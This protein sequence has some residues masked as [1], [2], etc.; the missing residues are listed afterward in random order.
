MSFLIQWLKQHLLC[1]EIV[2]EMKWMH[3]PYKDTQKVWVCCF[4]KAW[5]R[6]VAYLPGVSAEPC[7][8]F[9]GRKLARSCRSLSLAPLCCPSMA[10]AGPAPPSGSQLGGGSPLARHMWCTCG[11]CRFPGSKGGIHR[12]EAVWY[13]SS[14]STASPSRL[15][16]AWPSLFYSGQSGNRSGA[17]S[18]STT[19]PP[20]STPGP[21]PP[22]PATLSGW[23][24]WGWRWRPSQTCSPAPSGACHSP[25]PPSRHLHWASGPPSCKSGSPCSRRPPHASAE[26]VC[27]WTSEIVAVETCSRDK[28][29]RLQQSKWKKK[30]DKFTPVTSSLLKRTMCSQG[31]VSDLSSGAGSSV[32]GTAC[33]RSEVVL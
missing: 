5:V 10:A 22:A 12:L 28:H 3:F 6:W 7:S 24:G 11:H 27:T 16:A 20:G 9:H 8:C 23:S 19:S 18:A 13:H 29:K 32:R 26:R 14:F 30:L 1:P 4:L 15:H 33:K 31:C 2:A 21:L 25:G 17:R